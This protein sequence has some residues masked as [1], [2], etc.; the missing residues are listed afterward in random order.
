MNKSYFSFWDS[1]GVDPDFVENGTDEFG[2]SAQTVSGAL[3]HEQSAEDGNVKRW[4][5]EFWERELMDSGSG[6]EG[7]TRVDDGKRRREMTTGGGN[8]RI[9]VRQGKK[10]RQMSEEELVDWMVNGG[11]NAYV[12]HDGKIVTADMVSRLKDC[13]M[14]R[15]VN[16][17]PGGGR[18][19]K[20]G[21]EKHRRR[22]LER[23][24]GKLIVNAEFRPIVM[25]GENERGV[26]GPRCGANEIDCF[27]WTR[28]LDRGLGQESHGGRRRRRGRS[29]GMLAQSDAG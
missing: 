28:W 20:A 26:Q 17:L 2:A 3:A 23:D 19:K 8:K 25:D 29:L 24:G 22:R 27:H 18:K 12:V 13:A 4:Y 1:P 14:I 7:R 16:R 11:G 9:Y 10:I 15:L 5:M 21:S 6:H